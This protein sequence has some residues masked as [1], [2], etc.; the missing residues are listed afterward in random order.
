MGFVAES[1]LSCVIYFTIICPSICKIW[2]P[3]MCSC[4]ILHSRRILTKF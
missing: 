1:L 3:F 2:F 4:D